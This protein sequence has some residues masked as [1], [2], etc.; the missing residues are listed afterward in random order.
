MYLYLRFK[1]ILIHSSANCFVF[2]STKVSLRSTGRMFSAYCSFRYIF[3]LLRKTLLVT[4]SFQLISSAVS[5]Y[6]LLIPCV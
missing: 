5:L 4:V 6:T 1:R 3:A 2:F